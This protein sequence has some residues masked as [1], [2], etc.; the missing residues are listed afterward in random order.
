MKKYA[1][2]WYCLIAKENNQRKEHTFSSMII[3]HLKNLT[4]MNFKKSRA[5]P[6]F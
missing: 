6:Y 1:F 5:P 2:L 4:Q 3:P